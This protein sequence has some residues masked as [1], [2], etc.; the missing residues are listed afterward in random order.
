MSQVLAVT[1]VTHAH[2]LFFSVTGNICRKPG[3]V[4]NTYL[5]KSDDSSIAHTEKQHELLRNR[6]T[7]KF[8]AC[9]RHALSFSILKA[10]H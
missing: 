3:V 2:V 8:H 1:A 10:C 5:K 4:Y 6:G 9:F 7:T